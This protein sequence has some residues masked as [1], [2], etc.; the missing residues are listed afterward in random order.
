MD[1]W[2]ELKESIE[3]LQKV[4]EETPIEDLEEYR[5]ALIKIVRARELDEIEKGL[6][7]LKKYKDLHEKFNRV[8][9]N[10]NGPNYIIW[11]I[12]KYTTREYNKI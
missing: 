8:R 1:A 7:T 9:G 2:E 10:D 4:L 3:L 12:R 11:A 5:D 6:K